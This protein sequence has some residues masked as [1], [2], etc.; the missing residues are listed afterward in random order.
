MVENKESFQDDSGVPT[1]KSSIS[2]DEYFSLRKKEV[3]KQ[4]KD[5]GGDCFYTHYREC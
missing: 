1:V 3:T 5:S 4:K 2:L